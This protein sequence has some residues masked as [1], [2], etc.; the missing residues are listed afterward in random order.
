MNYN[1]LGEYKNAMSRWSSGVTIVTS[2]YQN[3]DFGMTVGSFTSVSLLPP[4]V[5][6]C[7]QS[8]YKSCRVIKHSKKFAVNILSKIHKNIGIVFSSK[9]FSMMQ[10]FQQ[11]YWHRGKTGCLILDDCLSFF[12]CK[13][14]RVYIFGD[15]TIFI[16]KVLN[17]GY[18]NNK[19][20][21]YHN[22]EW[23]LL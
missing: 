3:K 1:F 12:D 14:V 22:R 20:L 4:L 19:P 6:I 10:R 15:H 23:F 7:I 2:F 18:K 21:L 13:V 8:E 9:N 16:G 17:V 11:L 5:S